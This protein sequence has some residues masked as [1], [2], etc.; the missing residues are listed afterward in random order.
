[1]AG[2][3]EEVVG[4]HIMSS[5]TVGQSSGASSLAGPGALCSRRPLAA[6]SIFLPDMNLFRSSPSSG[7]CLAVRLPGYHIVA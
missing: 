6:E 3:L 4:S 5:L 7:V 2:P 1:M